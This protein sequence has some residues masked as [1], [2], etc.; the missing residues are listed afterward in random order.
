[1]KSKNQSN[2]DV[3]LEPLDIELK[4]LKVTLDPINITF[5]PF[6]DIELKGFDDINLAYLRLEAIERKSTS[7]ED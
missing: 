2:L 5:S 1:M 3:T 7:N 4:T 6:P